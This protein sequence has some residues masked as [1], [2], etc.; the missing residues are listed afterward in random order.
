MAKEMPHMYCKVTLRESCC[1]GE[2]PHSRLCEFSQLFV[3]RIKS[4]FWTLRADSVFAVTCHA[5]SPALLDRL[6]RTA[7][8]FL[9]E[10]SLE[11]RT[12][13]KRMILNICRFVGREEFRRLVAKIPGMDICAP[14]L[15]YHPPSTMTIP[16]V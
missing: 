16:T 8:G 4:V 5:G 11:T 1:C 6:F 12:H 15:K 14:I 10:G 2:I 9:E 7:V 3:L 13:G